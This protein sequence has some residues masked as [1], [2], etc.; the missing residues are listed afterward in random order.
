MTSRAVD[1]DLCARPN[2]EGEADALLVVQ[3]PAGPGHVCSPNCGVYVDV[4]KPAR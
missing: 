1:P 4:P 2:C 3:T